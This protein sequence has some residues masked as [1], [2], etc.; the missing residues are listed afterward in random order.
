MQAR[1]EARGFI[2]ELARFP[3]AI[4][5]M[6]IVADWADGSAIGYIVRLVSSAAEILGW[7]HARWRV[8][9]AAEL[10]WETHP[11]H[12]GHGYTREAA[13]L[14]VAELFTRP[15]VR[16]VHAWIPESDSASQGVAIA[17]GMTPTDAPGGVFQKW[18]REERRPI[19]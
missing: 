2:D 10:S 3:H 9:G 11:S 15:D 18:V 4:H 6:R 8:G 14:F 19:L 5:S 16:E 13:P 17:C 12:R 7:G 1:D